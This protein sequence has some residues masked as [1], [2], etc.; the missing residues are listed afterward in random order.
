MRR[1]SRD[2]I[3]IR[4][5]SSRHS[6]KSYRAFGNVVSARLE[7]IA[8]PTFLTG[9]GHGATDTA[10]LDDHEGRITLKRLVVSA[11]VDGDLPSDSIDQ[12]VSIRWLPR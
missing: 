6:W 8:A 4:P 11:V 5:V 10:F 9:S 3:G 12:L 1:D 2:D 7:W